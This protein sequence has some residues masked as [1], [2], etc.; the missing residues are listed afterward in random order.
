[1]SQMCNAL[2]HDANDVA[3]HRH[4]WPVE[5]G[6]AVGPVL[7]KAKSDAGRESRRPCYLMTS[8]E[9]GLC[10]FRSEAWEAPRAA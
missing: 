5:G 9:A 1:M 3:V 4:P 7:D 2:R 6:W 10:R 8:L